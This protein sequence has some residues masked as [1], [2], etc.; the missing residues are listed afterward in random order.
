VDSQRWAGF[1][2]AVLFND[3]YFMPLMFLLS[4][5]FV[6]PSLGRKGR[7]AGSNDGLRYGTV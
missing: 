7:L 2:I 1:D 4:G 6:G 3:S 5:L